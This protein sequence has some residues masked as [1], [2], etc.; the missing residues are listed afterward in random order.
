VTDEVLRA[1]IDRLLE[2]KKTGGEM[3]IGPLNDVLSGFLEK[4]L[5]RLEQNHPAVADTRDSEKLDSVLRDILIEVNGPD[6]QAGQV[7]F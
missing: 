6:I 5:V 1:E 4:E 2:I 3:G 7:P